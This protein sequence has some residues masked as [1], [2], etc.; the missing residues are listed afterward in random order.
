MQKDLTEVKIF[1]KVLGVTFFLKHRGLHLL[2]GLQIYYIFI[3]R[4]VSGVFALARNVIQDA[5]VQYILDNVIEELQKDESRHFIYVEIAFF[6]RWWRQQHD[7][8][9]HRV[10]ALVNAGQFPII[11]LLRRR[12]LNVV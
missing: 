6:S 2:A 3:D 8:T 7:V 11:T 5:G 12:H 9:R 4:C 1:Q 10:K